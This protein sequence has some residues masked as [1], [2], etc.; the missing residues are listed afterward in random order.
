MSEAETETLL[1]KLATLTESAGSRFDWETSPQYIRWK[2]IKQD[3][4]IL[5]Y[6]FTHTCTHGNAYLYSY[7][8]PYIH[9]PHTDRFETTAHLL[10]TS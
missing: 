6:A 7:A 10:E 1:S 8:C 2:I 3:V 5:S 9:M 4:W